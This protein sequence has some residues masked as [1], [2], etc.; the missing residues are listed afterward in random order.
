MG[1]ETVAEEGGSLPESLWVVIAAYNE[2][3]RIGAVLEDLLQIAKNVVVVDD[4]SRDDTAQEVLRHPV[5]LLRHA[6]NLGQGASLQTGI[7]FAIR[8]GAERIVTFDADGQH[9]PADI[10]TMLD[11]LNS[12]AADYALGSR[13]LGG[14]ADIPFFRKLVLRSAVLFTRAL[15][16]VSLTDAHNGIR[17]MTRKGA[18]RI[19]ITLNRMEHASEIVEQIAASGLK[20]VE[21]PVH[22]KYTA[23]SLAKG[24]K[25]S[26]AIVLAIKLLIE[27]VVR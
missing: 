15:S 8:Q 26:A 18:E 20:Y 19:R 12:N 16:G 10:R 24:Q 2:H 23:D 4:G 27:K 17:L 11:A 14:A 9:D 25:S 13:F 1:R 22:I 7:S 21:V 6:A 3:R 5:W